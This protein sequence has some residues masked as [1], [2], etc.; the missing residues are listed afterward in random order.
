MGRR[1]AILV[2]M[3]MMAIAT[4]FF[5]CAAYFT[6]PWVFYSV[7]MVGRLGQGVA[8]SLICICLPSV[9]QIEFPK[10]AE[11]YYGY[12]EMANGVGL[13]LGPVISSVVYIYAGYSG[14]FFFF[15]AFISLMGVLTVYCLLPKR[16]DT[17]DES[18]K[19]EGDEEKEAGDTTTD[20]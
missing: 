14:T 20:F 18:E 2:G 11:L 17:K 4:V 15:G 8:D 3:I 10:K 1:R 5:A 13:T 12:W 16:L 9:I 19:K 7:S 6:N